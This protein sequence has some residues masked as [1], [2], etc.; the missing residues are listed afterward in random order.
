M[1]ISQPRR[2]RVAAVAFALASASVLASC[3][4]PTAYQPAAGIGMSR[5]GYWDEQIEADRFRV[6]FAG[7]SL[8]S[9]ETV[10]RYLLFRAA[11][12][13][14]ERGFDYF[15]LSDRDTEKKTRTY[16]DRP[17]SAGAW[18]GWGPSWRYYRPRYGW[19]GWSPFYGDPFWDN[20][21]DVRTVDRYEASAE[22]VVGRGR[23]PDNVRAFTAR[24]V[25]QNLG[26]SI[27]APTPR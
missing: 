27:V 23:K 9:R 11:Q 20:D 3:A 21:I 1:R 4:T 16:V 8:T 7:N 25:I 17:F 14:V 5:T 2:S 22:L 13:T 6:T 18:G 15:I 12:L 10:E 24:E 19:R 26:P